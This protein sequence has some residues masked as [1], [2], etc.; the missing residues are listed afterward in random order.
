MPNSHTK[1]YYLNFHWSTWRY[2]WRDRGLPQDRQEF[3]SQRQTIL[4]KGGMFLAFGVVEEYV[5]ASLVKR[6]CV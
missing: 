6:P 1:A 3:L 4:V 2:G 5:G